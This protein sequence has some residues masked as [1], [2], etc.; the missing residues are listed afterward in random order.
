MIHPSARK[1]RGARRF[2]AVLL[3]AISVAAP[4]WAQESA[5]PGAIS[6]H[7]FNNADALTGWTVTRDAEIDRTKDRQGQCWGSFVN[8]MWAKHRIPLPAPA[9]GWNQ[10]R[11]DSYYRAAVANPE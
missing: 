11:D 4:G 3:A 5:A 8:E 6:K 1:A 7:D 9:N 2:A 10:P